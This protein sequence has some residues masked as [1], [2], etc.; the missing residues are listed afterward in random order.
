MFN[1]RIYQVEFPDGHVEEFTAN[2]IA[3]CLYSQI[4]DEGRQYVL[5]DKIVDY[6]ATDQALAEENRFQ[7][8]YLR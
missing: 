7:N 4:D 8:Y 3:E 1:T 6:I 2:T 5:L